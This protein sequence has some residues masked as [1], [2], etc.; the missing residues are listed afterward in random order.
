MENIKEMLLELGIDAQNQ[1]LMLWYDT[2]KIYSENDKN[3]K[4]GEIYHILSEK[5]NKSEKNIEK[6][7]RFSFK[8]RKEEIKKYFN[9]KGK[10]TN[11]SF[12]NLIK[13]KSI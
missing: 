8:S 4:M 12:L 5:Y 3:Y 7:M 13:F 11:K 10:I 1:G 2:I 9:Y 6:I